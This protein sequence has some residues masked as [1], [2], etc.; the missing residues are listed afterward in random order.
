MKKRLFFLLLVI[1][2]AVNAMAY[3]SMLVDGYHWNVVTRNVM[4]DG[5]KTVVYGTR[6]EEFDGDSVINGVTYKKIVDV[7]S[8]KS[9]RSYIGRLDS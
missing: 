4:L 5:G 6:V 8:W 1:A 3:Q 2:L 7:L 9:R